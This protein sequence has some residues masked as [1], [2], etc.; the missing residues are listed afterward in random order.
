MQP[1]GNQ[2]Y[3]QRS[4]EFFLALEALLQVFAGITYPPRY[5]NERQYILLQ[6]LIAIQPIQGFKEDIDTFVLELIPTAGCII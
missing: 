2:R 5:I 6:I 1:V 3:F 4:S